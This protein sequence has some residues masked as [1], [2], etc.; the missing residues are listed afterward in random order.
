MNKFNY[1]QG[2]K[3]FGR[4]GNRTI[5]RMVTLALGLAVALVLIAKIS[6]DYSYDRFWADNERICQIWYQT[7]NDE[8]DASKESDKNLWGKV[9]GG[10]APGIMNEI[11]E[12]EVATRF[13]PYRR[14]ELQLL[15]SKEKVVASGI[16]VDE[17]FFDIFQLPILQ[18]SSP[19]ELLSLPNTCL[20]SD[21]LAEKIQDPMNKRLVNPYDKQNPLVIVGIFKALP[22]NSHLD[23]DY[24]VSMRPSSNFE[25]D[26]MNTWIGATRFST[27]VKL[28]G[29]ANLKQTESLINNVRSKYVSSDDKDKLLL[30][31]L[32]KI[33]IGDSQVSQRVKLYSIIAFAI[34]LTI[35]LNYVLMLIASLMNRVKYIAVSKCYGATQ[36]E[37]YQ[38]F[39]V[40]TVVF[41]VA[42]LL[43]AS[44]LTYIFRGY[45]QEAMEVGV[46]LLYGK[47]AV[48][49]IL[50]VSLIMILVLSCLS[51][52]LFY[53]IP[54]GSV[55]GSMVRTGNY[56]KKGLLFVQFAASAFMLTLLLFTSKQYD[57][58]VSDN[59]GYEY[60]HIY[61]VPIKDLPEGNYNRMKEQLLKFPDI[62]SV[63]AA[64]N[65]FYQNVTG[66]TIYV[67]GN[68]KQLSQV[69][70]LLY[71]S[72]NFFKTMGV[73]LLEGH[74]F[75]ENESTSQ[76]AL[77]S[78]SLAKK[79][80]QEM[81]W[82]D[83]VIGKEIILPLH[84][85]VGIGTIRGIYSDIRTGSLNIGD[86]RTYAP[87]I[88]QAPSLV[89]CADHQV[90]FFLN[91]MVVRLRKHN[92]ELLR[93]MNNLLREGGNNSAQ[94]T[95]YADTMSAMYRGTYTFRTTMMI[96][97]LVLLIIS[98]IGVLGY[99]TNEVNRRSKE[100]AIRK[101]NGASLRDILSL[102]VEK[103]IW[104]S[105]PA[106][107]VGVVSSIF[108]CSMWSNNFIVKADV[109]WL[110]YIGVA[111]F[112]PCVVA[113]VTILS[114]WH[115][116][117]QNPVETLRLN[118]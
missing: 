4:K 71:C 27:Y 32:R 111:G 9:S 16:F 28:K 30:M 100:L 87:E 3:A 51:S 67:P 54:I 113:L 2:I 8:S 7:L 65:L 64:S 31:P 112:I 104:L 14:G 59:P 96:G 68:K 110:L 49:P 77:V 85:E 19:S 13:H 57:R 75:K 24:V 10:V 20:I 114:S 37:L 70:D 102:F 17:Y 108:V 60:E 95:S 56:W 93:K 12:I 43:A 118:F 88:L 79:L 117:R 94:F 89:F 29:N 101:I 109:S 74:Y 52:Y 25:L 23:F 76:D 35:L 1:Y 26:G 73:P 34:L 41:F 103:A 115:L 6:Y 99:T 107:F 39:G 38:Q 11:S 83:G 53:Q 45:I 47:T 21:K 15:D 97:T 22:K 46:S 44:F 33:H 61:S 81:N 36:K 105:L 50:L 55:F 66:N 48:V 84:D 106:V 58:L 62:V 80:M 18:G 5:S 72:P 86:K 42:S 63:A 91:F 90:D 98:I 78:E 116:A 92:P 40:E 82:S 69:R